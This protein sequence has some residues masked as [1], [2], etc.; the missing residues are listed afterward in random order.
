MERTTEWQVNGSEGPAVSDA[1]APAGPLGTFQALAKRFAPRHPLGVLR[2]PARPFGPAALRAAFVSAQMRGGS[3]PSARKQ[4]ANT[5]TVASEDFQG[6]FRTP[7]V[8]SVSCGSARI[9]AFQLVQRN[10]RY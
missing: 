2:A 8:S 9:P 6:F 4:A 3:T 5:S 1:M 7:F 10:P